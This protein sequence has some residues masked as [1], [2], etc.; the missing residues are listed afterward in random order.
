MDLSI[1][2]AFYFASRGQGFIALSDT[3]TGVA[4]EVPYSTP[5]RVLLSGL[6]A[7]EVFAGYTRHGTAYR[8][9]GFPGLISELELDVSRLGQRNLGRDDRVLTHWRRE[10]RY[11]FLDEDLLAWA[12]AL[13]VWEKTGFGWKVD[14]EADSETALDPE[15]QAL[16]LLA[17]RL[18]MRNV[19]KEKKRAIQFGSRT[20]K[21]ES[22]RS[23]GTQ[24]LAS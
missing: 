7:D 9:Q 14:T 11:P 5:A 15:K 8:R 21:M 19:A 16:R 6:G 20:A 24:L 18:G 4:V 13:P 22:G 3:E 12:L 17:W 2:C 10:A 23:K 1:A